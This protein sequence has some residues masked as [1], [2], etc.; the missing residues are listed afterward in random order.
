MCRSRHGQRHTVPF[1]RLSH[2]D[3]S[4]SGDGRSC[5]CFQSHSTKDV[6]EISFSQQ[7]VRKPFFFGNLCQDLDSLAH[8]AHEI[9]QESWASVWSTSSTSPV[10]YARWRTTSLVY[11]WAGPVAKFSCKTE[12]NGVVCALP[13][14]SVL[15]GINTS[16]QRRVYVASEHFCQCDL[17]DLSFAPRILSSSFYVGDAGNTS[18]VDAGTLLGATLVVTPDSAGLSALGV[19]HPD[20]PVMWHVHIRDLS[21]HS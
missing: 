4:F 10:S 18:L 5:C 7:D 1:F 13:V 20:V 2:P 11:H 8:C 12:V 14:E 17:P 9:E 19:L 3:I 16:T 21:P 15:T 6:R